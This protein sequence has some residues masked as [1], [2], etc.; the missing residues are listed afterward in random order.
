M[1]GATLAATL[2]AA[3]TA[4][5]AADTAALYE[6]LSPQHLRQTVERCPV[7]WIPEGIL[8]WHGE[9]S[10]CGLDALKAETLC[11]MAAGLCGGVCFPTLWLGPDAST[12][13]DPTKYPRG[14]LTIPKDLYY[15]VAEQMLER[16]ES[17][18]FRVAVYLSGH[19]PAVIPEVVAQWNRR[20]RMHV[21]NVSEN[22]VVQGMPAG[23][24][25]AAWETALLM[26]LR[27]GLVDMTRLPPLSPTTRPAGDR[28]P[29]DEPF[30]PRSEYYGVYRSDPRVW[31]GTYYGRRGVEAVLDGLA[32]E[33][34]KAL[35]DSAFGRKGRPIVW[36][37]DTRRP[38]E[39]RYDHLLPYQWLARF[40]DAPIVYWP[41]PGAAADL[42]R[43]TR[44]A[45]GLAHRH[46]GLVFP[47]LVYGGPQGSD[48]GVPRDTM[49]EVVQVVLV[50]LIDMGFRAVMLLQDGDARDTQLEASLRTS[51]SSGVGC[52]VRLVD[53][54]AADGAMPALLRTVVPQDAKTLP[55]DDGWTVNGGWHVASLREVV[56]GAPGERC[57]YERG[58][59]LSEAEANG[60][61]LL[62]LGGVE[63]RCEVFLNDLATPVATRHFPPYRFALDGRLRSGSN[64]LKVSIQHRPQD[65][66]D[67]FFYRSGP[68]RLRGPVV[69][70]LWTP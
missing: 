46:G 47:A 31:A 5:S 10:A 37:E 49:R 48:L 22:Q 59:V 45:V 6:R 41:L 27:P 28:I 50:R 44:E 18:G 9:Q 53:P 24:H 7:A 43:A 25:A 8:E 70:R 1:S 13:F 19:Y 60:H 3:V 52:V 21:I 40:E 33:V 39:V 26:V 30:L 20:G 34:G 15:R 23:D 35:R 36:P 57:V 17:M 29:P 4:T 56:Y 2:F 58:F 65:G 61:V 51:G 54:Q 69:L 62:D 16:I 63:N 67:H 66:L 68:P 14:T 32:H 38:P 55:L 42:E 11:R 64:V 12:P